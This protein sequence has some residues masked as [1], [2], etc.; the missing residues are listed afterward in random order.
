MNARAHQLGKDRKIMNKSVDRQYRKLLETLCYKKQS[1]LSP[2]DYMALTYHLLLQ[3]C[4][5]VSLCVLS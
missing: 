4:E 2:H 1:D 5:C 3:V